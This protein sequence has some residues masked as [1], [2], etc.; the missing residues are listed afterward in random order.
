MSRAI[1][2]SRA[3]EAQ[4][5]HLLHELHDGQLREAGD[6]A[7]AEAHGQRLGPQ[8][9]A[10]ADG[11]GLLGSPPP[12]VPPDLLPRLLGIEAR[13]G[14]DP[15][16]ST[17]GTS[18][19]GSCTRRAG[20]PALRSSCRTGDT[21]AAWRR[22]FPFPLPLPGRPCRHHAD[23]AFAEVQ[24]AREQ[25]AHDALPM[26]GSPLAAH[27]KLDCVLLEP[28][29]ARPGCRG[30]KLSIHAKM[31]ETLC[32]CPRGEVGVVPLARRDERGKHEDPLVPIGLQ[33]AR[34]D[35]IRRLRLDRDAAVR[36]VLD[37][38]LHEQQPQ[39]GI[40]LGE[41]R[42]G[43]LPAAAARALLDCH[44]RGDAVDPVHVRPARRLYELPRIGVQR[45]Q[46]PALP[47]G[48]EDVEG[49]RAFPAPAHARDD[50]ERVT[51]EGEVDVFQ[52]VLAGVADHDRV[53][54]HPRHLMI[55]GVRRTAGGAG[56]PVAAFAPARR[57]ALE[58][59]K[60][61]AAQGR[62]S[63]A[64]LHGGHFRGGSRADDPAALLA[65][66]RPQVDDPV[67]GADHVEVVLDDDHGMPR[68]H[69]A[70]KC[71]QQRGDVVEMETRGGL[72]E[73][74]KLA[75]SVRPGPRFPQE[76]RELQP[77][78]L[79]TAQGG[80]GLPQADV[81][82]ADRGKR[83]QAREHLGFLREEIACLRHR[84]VQDIGNRP[85]RRA[86][87][88]TEA[89]RREEAHVE[90]LLAE[91]PAVAVGAAQVHVAQELH[92]DVL[93]AGAAARRAA[94][95]ARV[96]AERARRV[97]ALP[98]Q[99]LCGKELADGVEGADVA[100]GVGTGCPADGGLVD[101]HHVI[102][103][104]VARNGAVLPR[105]L[106]GLVLDRRQGV[107]EH[108]LHESRLAG[109]AHAGDAHEPAQRDVHVDVF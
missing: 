56:L 37:A 64:L 40:D 65:A 67:R 69:E 31:L 84:H 5:L 51:R 58:C 43:A 17:R 16:R 73:E 26:R 59:R 15:S 14:E 74:E 95:I 27:G 70:P 50:A 55:R 25:L 32:G 87:P 83:R 20:D 81:S 80:N 66:L 63:P 13:R 11:A 19:A 52:I 47:F 79:P 77:L 76:A 60:P 75:A 36:A 106:H 46:V 85:G 28:V 44:G 7:V 57:H 109:P 61:R 41:R 35:C 10:L 90:H 23:R 12:V 100:H 68:F 102:H 108:V 4:S 72:V 96:E 45:F 9:L 98:G 18:R 107:E 105:L 62:A 49:D 101:E 91:A 2:P 86:G 8:A 92:L 39:E 24:T 6:G 21:R 48:E 33:H 99:R 42:N 38:E 104:L 82:Q 54:A 53:V 88:R 97:A 1:S 30:K 94:A 71:P 78:R 29:Q 22:P 89:P 93:E 3:P 103:Q 34:G